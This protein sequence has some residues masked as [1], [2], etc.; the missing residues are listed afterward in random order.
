MK[1]ICAGSLR[2]DWG[3]GYM[4]ARRGER[5]EVVMDKVDADRFSII[6]RDR[7]LDLQVIA[8]TGAGALDF[9]INGLRCAIEQLNL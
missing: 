3:T 6:T 9:W 1:Q 5:A 4:Y 8:K 7:K 2:L